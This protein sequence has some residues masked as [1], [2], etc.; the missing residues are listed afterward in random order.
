LSGKLLHHFR[1]LISLGGGNP[2]HPE[3]SRL[4]TSKLQY[5]FGNSQSSSGV[6]IAGIVV[7]ITGMTAADEHAVRAELKSPKYKRG[8]DAAG[9]HHPDNPEILRILQSCCPGQIR[10]GVCAPIAGYAQYFRFK[11]HEKFSFLQNCQTKTIYIKCMP[12]KSVPDA[13]RAS[14]VE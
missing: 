5:L 14:I 13:R 8:I 2:L 1:E 6:K 7:A 12:F 9:A 3:S 10:S 4:E 11:R